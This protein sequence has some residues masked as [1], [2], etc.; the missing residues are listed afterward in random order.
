[1]R[2]T[3]VIESIELSFDDYYSE[4]IEIKGND[5]VRCNGQHMTI[6]V[7]TPFSD[8]DYPYWTGDDYEEIDY[9]K[10]EIDRT[11]NLEIG[12]IDFTSGHANVRI[13][14]DVFQAAEITECSDPRRSLD[15]VT[16]AV[17]EDFANGDLLHGAEGLEVKVNIAK[18]FILE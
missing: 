3:D 18:E 9:I 11:L 7:T 13:I 16:K 17:N 1:M 14:S 8:C 5:D 12:E 2:L 10:G 4:I 6:D 15:D